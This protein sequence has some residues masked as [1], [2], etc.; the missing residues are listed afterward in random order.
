MGSIVWV[1]F[2]VLPELARA[3]GMEGEEGMDV[4]RGGI[5]MD[6]VEL[7]WISQWRVRQMSTVSY[8]GVC[9]QG[10]GSCWPEM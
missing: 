8:R 7:T 3:D 5:D 9:N 2:W 10:T 1:G 6:N 4:N